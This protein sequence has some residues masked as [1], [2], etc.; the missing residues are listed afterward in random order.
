MGHVRTR[1]DPRWSRI[2]YGIAGAR[3]QLS[4]AVAAMRRRD[5][6]ED[7]TKTK[8]R[9]GLSC[10][11]LSKEGPS[12]DKF[13]LRRCQRGWMDLMLTCRNILHLTLCDDS[14]F[15][16]RCG[17]I[18]NTAQR[19]CLFS[20]GLIICLAWPLLRSVLLEEFECCSMI[21]RANDSEPELNVQHH[22]WF[23]KRQASPGRKR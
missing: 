10:H 12:D 4:P 20:L 23:L 16:L 17:L 19:K 14:G 5:S 7:C 18:A 3:K 6:A 1:N 11:F 9:E 15:E 8:K 22:G 2:G 13:G 21:K